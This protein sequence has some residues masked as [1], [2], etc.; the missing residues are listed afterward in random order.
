MI[1]F[2]LKLASEQQIFRPYNANAADYL[3]S[4]SRIV[5]DKG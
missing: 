3:R 5:R 4:P 1:L 2:R